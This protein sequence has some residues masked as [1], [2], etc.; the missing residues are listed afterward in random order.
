M[1]IVVLEAPEIPRAFVDAIEFADR[2][3]YVVRYRR[4]AALDLSQVAGVLRVLDHGEDNGPA[5][6]VMPSVMDR[7]TLVIE[8]PPIKLP[9]PLEISDGTEYPK[10]LVNNILDT[11]SH[12]GDIS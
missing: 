1:N 11:P 9:A 12:A 6:E 10:N 7:P 3:I 8:K 5:V 2:K 4:A